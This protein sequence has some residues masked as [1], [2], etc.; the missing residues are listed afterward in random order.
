MG[1]ASHLPGHFP[2]R[3]MKP[4]CCRRTRPMSHITSM[5]ETHPNTTSDLDVAKLADCIAACFECAQT[6]TA[7][8][9]ACLG[10]E[11]V[12]EL[13]NCIRLNLD[14]ADIC[15]ATGHLLSPRP[16]SNLATVRAA[17]EARRIPCAACA[18]GREG[19][20][21][22][23]E[24]SHWCA[25]TVLPS[26]KNTPKCVSIAACVLRPVDAVSRLV[27][28]CWQLSA[29]P[30]Y[31]VAQRTSRNIPLPLVLWH[32]GHYFAPVGHRWFV[33][34]DAAT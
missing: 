4:L 32:Y 19:H 22:M 18:A 15:T 31:P 13:R 2:R 25:Q 30:P 1:V 16:G 3:R 9:D 33:A 21:D 17:L 6:C 34:I 5:I 24:Q 28:T 20:G 7:C 26:V 8:A 23:H 29:K 14:C 10:E 12:T 27:Q 11:M